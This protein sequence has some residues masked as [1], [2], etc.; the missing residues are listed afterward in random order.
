[1]VE[2]YDYSIATLPV[3]ATAVYAIIE[4][5]KNFVF[6]GNEKFKK[7]IPI[8]SASIGAVIGII[9]FFISPETIPVSAWYSAVIVGG[10][11]G[12]SAVG[13]NQIKK[14]VEKKEGGENS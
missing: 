13:I 2:I 5:L 4:F 3:I 1:M 11:S 12:L 14:Q 7:Y 8:I 6:S 9:V 10:A